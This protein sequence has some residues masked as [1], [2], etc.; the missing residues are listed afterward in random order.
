MTRLPFTLQATADKSRA[1]AGKLQTLHGEVETPIFMPV[2]TQATVKSQTV[3]TLKKAGSRILLANTYHLL[4]RPGIE[5]MEQFGG[6][7]RFMNWDGPVLTDSGGFQIFSLGH[8]IKLNEK[9]AL[10]R[11]YV[12]NEPIFLTPELSIRTQRAINSDI[13]MVLDQCIS[14]TAS[15]AEAKAAMDLTHRWAKRSFDAR[16]DSPQALFGI[17]QG[18]LHS[19]LRKESAE[20]LM[21]M[22]FDGL[23]IGGLAVG[24]SRH[25]REDFTEISVSYMPENLPRYLMGVGTPIDILEAVHRGVDMFDCILPNQYAQRGVAFTSEGKMQ[26]RRGIYK[27][28]EE[29]LDPECDCQ[30]CTDYSRAYLHHLTKTQE[31]LGW[32]LL[33][34]HNHHYYHKLMARIRHEILQCSFHDFYL[35]TREI[36]V[37]GDGEELK[38]PHRPKVKDRYKSL[39]DYEVHEGDRGF[40]SIR[41]KSS[42]EIMHSVNHPDEEARSIYITPA[43]ISKRVQE[44]QETIVW[45][46]GLGAAHNSM[47]LV[48]ELEKMEIPGKVRIL[49]FEQDLTPLELALKNPSSFTHLHH[50]G[51]SSLLK[52]NTW[53]CPSDKIH[54]ELVSGNFLE[55]FSKTAV[56]KIIFFDPFS[57]HTN[58]DLWTTEVFQKIFNHCK[59]ERTQLLTYSA[60]TR[61][62]ASL[63]G[64]GFFVAEGPNSG[65]KESTTQAFT[66]SELPESLG[67]ILL[68][69]EWLQKWNRSGARDPLLAEILENHPQFKT[70]L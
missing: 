22:D 66:N 39:G 4:L 60:S 3:Q 51:P 62:R 24:E 27:F 18:A 21:G 64:A 9:G 70:V 13:M 29:R 2:G 37:R 44:S 34:L 56:P 69:A 43:N 10:F 46:V 5:V 52:K 63:L 15:F 32:H 61:I 26:L 48:R 65:P 41:Q 17:V 1:R 20:T 19:E 55:T 36:L 47:A 25:E 49:S 53:S 28:S 67:I 35:K 40:F 23:A 6:I 11:S 45:D 33:S 14:S 68:Q 58:S 38:R 57:I 7:H 12:N 54:W 50:P 59:G 42:G 16:G 30:T 31:V 8:D